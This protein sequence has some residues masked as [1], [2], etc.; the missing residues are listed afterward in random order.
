MKVKAVRRREER[1]EPRPKV[2]KF[3]YGVECWNRRSSKREGGV[4]KIE[5]IIRPERVHT[6]INALLAAGEA[7]VTVYEAA[8]HGK[9][10]SSAD[11]QE[12][13]EVTLRPK[14][15]LVT[16]VKD[17]DLDKI[18]KVIAEAAGTHRVGDGKIFVTD[19]HDAIRIRTLEHGEKALG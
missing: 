13:S 9:Q 3:D 19:L 17:S 1:H 11:R 4:R 18:V 2:K 12:D 14:V 7:G 10:R 15:M 16:V 5:A 8:G 6:V